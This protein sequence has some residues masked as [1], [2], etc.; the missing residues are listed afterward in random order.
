MPNRNPNR[1]R[2]RDERGHAVVQHA[3]DLGYEASGEE[4]LVSPLPNHNVANE[5]RLVISRAL[6]HFGY[7]RSARVV[8]ADGN[9][10]FKECKDPQASH[11]VTFRLFGKDGARTYTFRQARGNPA[12]LKYNPYRRRGNSRFP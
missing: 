2:A 12:S 4:Y 11:G 7:P 6:E 3:V 8:D 1:V 5:S 9:P 10:C